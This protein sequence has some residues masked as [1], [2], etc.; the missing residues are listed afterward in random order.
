MIE[1][2]QKP[3]DC[4]FPAHQK[5]LSTQCQR[6]LK[7]EPYFCGFADYSHQL[8]GAF[9]KLFSNQKNLKTLAIHFIV[10]GKDSENGAC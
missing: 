3:V 4:Q 8:K 9:Q 10:D 5:A 7:T 1:D 2:L 6:K